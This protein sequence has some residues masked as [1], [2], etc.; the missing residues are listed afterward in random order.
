MEIRITH[1]SGSRAGQDTTYDSDTVTLGRSPSNLI[2][3]DP[4]KDILVSGRHAKLI[5]TV[6]GWSIED[7]GSTNGTFVDGERITTVTAL[8]PG[9]EIELGKGGARFRVDWGAATVVTPLMGGASASTPGPAEGRTVMM[10]MGAMQEGDSQAAPGMTPPTARV[11]A[12]SVPTK[13]KRSPVFLLL[14]V[15]LIVVV[16]GIALIALMPGESGTKKTASAKAA[17]T[18]TAPK[19]ADVDESAEIR[20]KLASQTAELERLQAE[21]K[22]EQGSNAQA[23]DLERQLREQQEM[24]SEL[25]RQL[26]SKNDQVA[27]ARRKAA[28]EAARARRA[29]EKAAEA[30]AKSESTPKTAPAPAPAKTAEPSTPPMPELK[31]INTKFLKRRITVKGVN[32][33][34]PIPELPDGGSEALAQMTERALATTGKYS[35]NDSGSSDTASVSLTIVGFHN[36][37][38]SRVNTERATE[39]VGGIAGLTGR[40][41][42]TVSGAGAKTVSANADGTLRVRVYNGSNRQVDDF[43]VSAHAAA[44]RTSVS[45]A[46]LSM[47]N[48]FQTDTPA[49]DVT[50][51]LVAEAVDKIM[52]QVDRLEW[53]ATV[54]AQTESRISIDCGRAC[55][56]EPGDVF[57]VV[58]KG[59]TIA[60]ATVVSVDNE[61]ATA[62][63]F[64]GGS[65][66][67]TG[68]S[69]H[70]AGRE[71]P[72]TLYGP[73]PRVRQLIVR[74]KAAVYAGPG[75]S[76]QKIKSLRGGT[77][78]TYLYSVGYWAKATDGKS[79]YWIEMKYAD[80]GN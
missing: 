16:L 41:V 17:A 49:G 26:Q 71:K 24:I 45:A 19:Q 27:N 80:V 18:T 14:F 54:K 55:Q 47:G 22:S 1:L 63:V 62:A 69:V 25:T 68:K 57:D 37:E 21:A 79:D 38:K 6:D 64:A 77:R 23:T 42:P 12:A 39:V 36:E 29:Q 72:S 35:N 76:F 78:L 59:R 33:D 53:I 48:L 5:Q 46:S 51:E 31:L 44:T 10:S 8:Q 70:Y 66:K 3:F 56:I 13:K 75:N 61:S 52:K 15:F 34:I 60:R 32:S 4:E 11:A 7:V 40:N 9:S 2:T 20:Q 30:A 43:R 58:D 65:N 28:A 73:T 50:R 74:R 67:L